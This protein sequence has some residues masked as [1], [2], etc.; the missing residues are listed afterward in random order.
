MILALDIG[1]TNIVIGYLSSEHDIPFVERLSTDRKK[2]AAEYAISI[3]TLLELSGLPMDEVEGAIISSV[4]P[5]ITAM[6]VEAIRKV[7][8]LQALVV[9]PGVKNGLRIK[10]DNP[11]QLGSDLVVDAV[12]ASA[13]YP[14]P[15]IVVDMGTATTVS[16]LDEE[17]SYI[18]GMIIPGVRGSLDALVSRAAQLSNISIEAPRR[19]IGKNTVECMQ[20]G[21][22]YG[23]AA[24]IDGLIDRIEAQLGRKAT[25]IATGG[26]AGVVVPHC[27][28]DVIVD[29][30][31]LLKGLF[32]IYQRNR[33]DRLRRE[34]HA[35]R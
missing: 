3:K 1:N 6:V 14:G 28:H 15:L 33:D 35:G 12:A 24:C 25:V 16:V 2:T 20:S 13:A 34:A 29:D 23:S 21:I 30:A 22:V 4:V 8:G 17:K 18:G 11:A 19:L 10:M 9:G 32:L 26:L 31:L 7:T 27:R 5:P